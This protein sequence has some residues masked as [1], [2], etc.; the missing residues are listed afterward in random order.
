MRIHVACLLAVGLLACTTSR[1]QA[2]E[3]L[4]AGGEGALPFIEDDYGRAL[5]EAKARGLPLFV[6]T[7]APWCHTCRSMKAYV[8]TDKALARHAGRFVWLELNTDLPQA[9]GFQEKY[10]IDFWP[11]FF[12]IDPR[13]ERV[14]VRFSGSA[15]VSQL[16]KLF[17][18]GER[19]W[20]GGSQGAEAQLA[21][22]DAL[23]G[24]GKPAEA[25]EAFA[26]A[27]AEA[28]TDWSRRGRTLESL[29]SALYGA[30]QHEACARKALEESPQVPRSASLANAMTWGLGCVLMLPPENPAGK[31]LLGK[32]EA[33]AREVLAPP[34]IEMPADDRSG[35]Y[36]V[37]VE[38]RKT[39]QDEAGTKVIAAEWLGF[40]E[41]EAAKAPNPEARTVFDSH[42]MVAA[43]T[44]GEPQR[45][46]PAIEQSERD[47]PNDYNP[48]ARLSSLYRTMGRLEEALAASGRA[49]EKVQGA[50]RL[51][52][53]SERSAIQADQGKK[54]AAVATL[55]EALAYA[56][57]LP[58][59]QVSQRQR[60]ALE[61]KLTELKAK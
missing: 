19:A 38:A 34:S 22:G 37:M 47:L 2:P 42:R 26:Q 7:W 12:I 40:L 53:L 30:K 17:E 49:L 18:D 56:K 25:A 27:L 59:A 39:L 8:F 57:A 9:A 55:E 13:E 3:A 16:E 6:D 54:E 44:L 29:L 60:E 50:R 41:A 1:T 61:K 28:P 48:P 15:T 5:A 20:R 46:V 23:Y 31:A 33:K 36:E 45:V 10:P 43:L 4:T 14:L 58:K 51:R 35:L 52:V 32:L 21:R 11:T 24:E